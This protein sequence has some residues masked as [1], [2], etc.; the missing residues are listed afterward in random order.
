MLKNVMNQGNNGFKPYSILERQCPLDHPY[1]YLNGAKCCASKDEI[2][3]GGSK[4]EIASGTCDG[5][6]FDFESTCCKNH[7]HVKCP[8]DSCIDNNAGKVR[9][10]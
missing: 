2:K 8:W 6:G 9:S 4:S 7:N 5:I 3:K 1:A 10:K